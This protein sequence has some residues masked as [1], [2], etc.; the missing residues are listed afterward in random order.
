MCEFIMRNVYGRILFYPD[1]NLAK[2]ICELAGSKTLTKQALAKLKGAG[3][4]IVIK[5]DDAGGLDDA[6]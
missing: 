3:V 4:E 6:A 2:V 1:N 5:Q